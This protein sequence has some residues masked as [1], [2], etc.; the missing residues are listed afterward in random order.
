MQDQQKT[1]D[2]WMRA[3]KGLLFKV[4]RSYAFTP[5]DRE[6][7][8]QEIATQVW[9]SIPS[10]RQESAV[11]TWLYRVALNCA[12]AW[13]R[14]RKKHPEATDLEAMEITLQESPEAKNPRLEW[15]YEQIAK[16]NEVDRSL[17]LLLLDGFSYRDIAETL[18]LSESNVGV[19]LNRIKA[20]LME[21][22]SLEN[23]R[24]L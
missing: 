9:R 14:D 21:R 22:M 8:F 23:D 24:E 7:L 3:H 15:L 18:G 16:L 20:R 11:T 12:L 19:K 4:V 17:T 13:S 6:D 1:F 5:H 10:F 2:E